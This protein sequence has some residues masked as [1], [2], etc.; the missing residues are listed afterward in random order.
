MCTAG[1]VTCVNKVHQQ[2]CYSLIPIDNN[3]QSSA[4]SED[5]PA[6]F[7]LRMHRA[8]T[9]ASWG[10]PL[11]NCLWKWSP[12][13]LLAFCVVVYR[14]FS[15]VS[16]HLAKKHYKIGWECWEERERERG[17]DE[18]G[19]KKRRMKVE[20]EAG[21]ICT[22]SISTEEKTSS[23]RMQMKIWSIWYGYEIDMT[24]AHIMWTLLHYMHQSLLT[25]SYDKE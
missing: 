11:I 25:P 14:G 7:Q 8:M 23:Q 16:L 10:T 15:T 20:R 19:E 3:I 9:L 6:S 1:E 13:K 21:S 5:P 22:P 24:L 4:I 18:T 12:L 2:E 17:E